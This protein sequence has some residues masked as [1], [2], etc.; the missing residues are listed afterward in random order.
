MFQDISNINNNTDLVYIT[1]AVVLIDL[2]V[3]LIAKNTNIF[4]K[5]INVWYD[6]LGMTAV[7]LDVTIIIIGF[8]ITRYIFSLSKI[9]FNPLYFIILALIVQL[10]HDSLLYKLIIEPTKYG[11]NTVIDIYKDYAKENGAKILAADSMMV[12]GSAI[13]AMLL[14][15][16]D[17]H[18]SSTLF[19]LGI[20]IIPYLIYIKTIN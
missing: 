12:L 6:K 17:M 2:L 4:K 11:I 8:I 18:V 19:I 3:I 1:T 5:Q 14:K 20:Y 9:E 7:L 13:I 15:N 16:T 10:V